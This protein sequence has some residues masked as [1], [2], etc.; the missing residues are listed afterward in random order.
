[1][2]FWP[3]YNHTANSKASGHESEHLH[4]MKHN[5]YSR[6][7]MHSMFLHGHVS[8]IHTQHTQHT[9]MPRVYKLSLLSTHSLQHFELRSSKGKRNMRVWRGSS[10]NSA[11]LTAAD[12]T[13]HQV[14]RLYIPLGVNSVTY[15][16]PINKLSPPCNHVYCFTTL[17]Q[18]RLLKENTLRC[19]IE[20]STAVSGGLTSGES[21][22]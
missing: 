13:E 11:G 22:S 14:V 7:Y 16:E 6:S 12:N 3:C 15:A 1:M 9:N 17:N 8:F 21:V 19:K 10:L 5:T 20:S 4:Y 2:I 18:S